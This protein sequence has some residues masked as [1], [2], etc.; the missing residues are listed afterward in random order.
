MI[1][2]KDLIKKYFKLFFSQWYSKVFAALNIVSAFLLFITPSITFILII[3]ILISFLGII[4]SSYIVYRDLF[5]TIPEEQRLAFLPPNIGKPEIEISQI[6]G[7]EYSFG[8]Y[9]NTR[10]LDE[11]YKKK[12]TLL[13]SI[14]YKS[15]LP[16][17]AAHF[18]FVF[19]NTGYIPVK[20][21]SIKAHIDVR[22]PLHFLVPDILNSNLEPI[23][24][25]IKLENRN[26]EIRIILYESIIPNWLL[27]EAQIAKL[28]GDYLA[29]VKERK[30]TI[31]IE[32]I[33]GDNNSF[34]LEK[35]FSFTLELLFKLFIENW[36]ALD[37]KDLLE[38][39]SR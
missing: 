29:D 24:Y 2:E 8:F 22:E 18:Y 26:D 34:N 35:E 4:A 37:E 30:I 33:D 38:L 7:N 20:I 17:M 16:D 5:F 10:N 3:V 31:A 36:E 14:D 1:D 21:L 15:V 12:Y 25:P 19:T 13:S 28:I 23:R 39:S 9:D 32:Y 11:A 27:T 6:G